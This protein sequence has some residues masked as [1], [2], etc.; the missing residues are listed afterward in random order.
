MPK[1]K[2]SKQISLTKVKKKD[3]SL[4]DGHIDEIRD[5]SG[6]FKY[7]LLISVE[8]ERNHFIKEVRRKLHPGRLFYGK[9]KLMQHSLGMTPECECQDN[10]HK[11]AERIQ[12]HSAILFTND[13]VAKIR[14]YFAEYQP[15]DYA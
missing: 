14:E 3:K 5:A 7:A 10:I 4:K 11:L 1:S 6:K 12:G 15:V 2:R 8:N 9:N 13:P